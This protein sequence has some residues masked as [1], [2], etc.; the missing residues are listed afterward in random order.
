MFQL[1]QRN[2]EMKE[3]TDFVLKVED[4][5]IHCHKVIMAAASRYFEKM[6]TSDMKESTEGRA[7]LNET[8]FAIINLIVNAIYEGCLE[9][10]GDNVQDVF[11]ACHHY[12][13]EL[14]MPLCTDYMFEHIDSDN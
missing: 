8:N 9:L 10:D 13:I 2:S 6:L 3:L 5:E 7:K 11:L 14:F 12:D 1:L 4:Q